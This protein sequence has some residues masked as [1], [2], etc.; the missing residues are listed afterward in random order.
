MFNFLQSFRRAWVWVAVY[1]INVE[2]NYDHSQ[3]V[4]FAD[5]AIK[6]IP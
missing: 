3:A 6:H 2:Q 4:V 5:H 1:R